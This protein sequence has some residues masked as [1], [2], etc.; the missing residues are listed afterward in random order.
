[1]IFLFSLSCKGQKSDLKEDSVNQI[2]MSETK[3]TKHPKLAPIG[4]ESN[5]YIP[6]EILI[7]FKDD[8]DLQ[9]IKTIQKRLD[10]TTIKVVPKLNIYRMKIENGSS[11]EEVMKRLQE[12]LEVEYSEPNYMV[13]FQ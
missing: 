10:L 2:N 6:G 1:M 9:S 13:D 11:V 7:K 5:N 12:F 4:K 8:T 3:E